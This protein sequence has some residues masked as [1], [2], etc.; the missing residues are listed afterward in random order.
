[1]LTT[2]KSIR[3]IS[4]SIVLFLI[5]ST[6]IKAQTSKVYTVAVMPFYEMEQ[7]PYV[8]DQVRE[9]LI[10]ELT[11]KKYNVIVDD[12]TWAIILDMDYP[13]YFLNDEQAKGI[14][15]EIDADLILFGNLQDY[16]TARPAGISKN[17]SVVKPILVKIYDK[18]KDAIILHERMNFNQEWGLNSRRFTLNDFANNIV[19][20]MKSMGY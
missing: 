16:S 3:I 2:K 4:L 5:I 13:L 11:T 6:A 9:S 17:K 1:M 18:N 19:N 14:S 15:Q 20:R 7:Y 10:F 8:M 12:S